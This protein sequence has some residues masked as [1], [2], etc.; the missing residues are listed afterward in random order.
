MD[1]DKAVTFLMRALAEGQRAYTLLAS[2]QGG[3]YDEALVGAWRGPRPRVDV[4][5]YPE[6]AR[7]GG[8]YVGLV[9]MGER[10]DS[11]G[12]HDP[13]TGMAD[14]WTLYSRYFPHGDL[15]VTP[16]MLRD[17]ASVLDGLGALARDL[18]SM[19]ADG[20]SETRQKVSRLVSATGAYE[21]AA[22]AFTWLDREVS[23][24]SPVS[25]K[26]EPY[27]PDRYGAEK[28]DI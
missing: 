25:L 19:R 18:D 6:E 14:V 26:D 11:G 13:E 17:F 16:E 10:G 23:G 24:L 27:H 3:R 22:G 12:L 2:H 1:A 21:E 4:G 28:H 7:G 9:Y 8:G 20:F 15:V 5:V